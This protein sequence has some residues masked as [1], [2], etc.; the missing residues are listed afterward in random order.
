MMPI[1][2]HCKI[3]GKEIKTYPSRIKQGRAKYCSKHK[4]ATFIKKGERRSKKTEFKKGQLPHNYKGFSYT[5]S[6]EKGGKYKMIYVPDHPYATKKK[7]VREHRLVMEKY[8]GRYLKPDEVVHH[9]NGNTLDNRIEN[10]EL[11]NKKEHDR[12]NVVLNVHK[13]WVERGGGAYS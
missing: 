2:R 12:R 10:L 4:S 8:L 9:K 7:Q 11:L 3:C 1:I 5:Q 6:R 13:R